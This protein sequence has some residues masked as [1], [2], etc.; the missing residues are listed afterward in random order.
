MQRDNVSSAVAD[1][2]SP[3]TCQ[4]DGGF[5][6]ESVRANARTMCFGLSEAAPSKHIGL[7]PI[8]PGLKASD[9]SELRHLPVISPAIADRSGLWRRRKSGMTGSK[10][11][12]QTR[13]SG[14][15][16]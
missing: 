3:V 14:A 9:H 10:R 12:Q 8:A 6:V 15:R 11:N 4:H 5:A 2:S 1:D 16:P 7:N 13:T